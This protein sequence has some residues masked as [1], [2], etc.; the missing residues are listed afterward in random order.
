MKFYDYTVKTYPSIDFNLDVKREEITVK[1]VYSHF[2]IHIEE[3]KEQ[4][5]GMLPSMVMCGLESTKLTSD[6]QFSKVK[7]SLETRGTMT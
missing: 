3:V 2:D 6:V 4:G 5:L 1:Q 7:G